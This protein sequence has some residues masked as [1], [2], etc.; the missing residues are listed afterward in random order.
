MKTCKIILIILY[1]LGILIGLGKT[2]AADGDEQVENLLSVIIDAV[3]YG[4]LYSG[5]GIFTLN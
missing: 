1:V 4:L 5:A 2:L 3:I